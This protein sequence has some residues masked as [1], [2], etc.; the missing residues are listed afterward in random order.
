MNDPLLAAFPGLALNG[1][2]ITSPATYSY[3]C[4]AW[5]AARNDRWW[6]PAPDAYWPPAAPITTTLPAFEAAY[7]TLG[8]VRC[9]D[10][11]FEIRAEKIAIY[12]SPAGEPTH[13]ARQLDRDRWT[14]KLGPNVDIEHATPDALNGPDYGAPALFMRRPRPLWRW[15]FLI[16]KHSYI[17]WKANI[18]RRT[19]DKSTRIIG[20]TV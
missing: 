5:A 14:S 9:S 19:P 7:A 4:I 3:N 8:Y 11:E 18:G 10:A 2:R 17:K 12:A 6:W 20:R 15:P 16:L 1:Y 13:A